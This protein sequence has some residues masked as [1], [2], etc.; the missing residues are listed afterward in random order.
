MNRRTNDEPVRGLPEQLPEGE[1][2]LWQGAPAWRSL[3][4]RLF[5][6]RTLAVYFGILLIWR[7]ASAVYEGGGVAEA[8]AATYPLLLLAAAAFAILAVLAWLIART[9]IYTVTN[10]RLAMRFGVALPMTVNLPFAAVEAADLREYKGGTGDISLTLGGGRKIGYLVL[11]PHARPFKLRNPQPMMRAIPDASRVADLMADRL[12]AIAA[13]IPA[14]APAPVPEPAETAPAPGTAS[15]AAPD[16]ARPGR[17]A[18]G[19]A[20]PAAAS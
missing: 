8:V 7:G 19:Q 17:A 1:Q 4:L 5:R 12:A 11:W 13:T 2:I 15:D 10:K 20:A 16:R 9:T 18:A 14:P 3:A 6:F